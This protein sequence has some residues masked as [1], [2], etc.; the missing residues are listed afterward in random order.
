[1]GQLYHQ[2]CPQLCEIFAHLRASSYLPNRALLTCLS[3][4]I[5]LATTQKC[6]NLQLQVRV[7]RRIAGRC[8]RE[9]GFDLLQNSAL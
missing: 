6:D 2:C 3:V 1:M 5:F 4:I 7:S 9:L 8:E